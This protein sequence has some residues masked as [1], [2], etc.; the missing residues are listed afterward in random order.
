ML[1][2]LFTQ[3]A[4]YQRYWDENNKRQPVASEIV[5]VALGDSTAQ[6][7]GASK[8]SKGYVSLVAA[9]IN[10]KYGKPVRTVNLSRSGARIADALNQQLPA[11]EKLGLKSEPIITIEIGANDMI[12][13]D[14]Q[15]FQS[16]TD[17]LMSKLPSQ[18]IMSD[19]PSFRGSRFAS[20]EPNI[21]Q[22]NQIM[23]KLAEKHGLKLAG[24]HERVERNHGLRTFARDIFHPSDYGYKT[25]WAPA[26]TEKLPDIYRTD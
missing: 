23:Y 10:K 25:N 18:T 5:Y 3:L 13:F 2:E 12:N 26:F 21:I 24:L 20:R 17:M 6:A 4:R 9:E 8:P 15:K 16:E 19:I 22:A 14:A 11:Y 7:I 1:L